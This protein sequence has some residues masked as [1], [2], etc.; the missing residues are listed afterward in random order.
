MA[1]FASQ[2]AQFSPYIAPT[3]LGAQAQRDQQDLQA[4]IQVGQHKQ[5]MY[6]VNAQKIQG[7][8][9]QVS[10][11]SVQKDV[12]KE[13]LNQQIGQMQTDLNKMMKSD[14]SKQQVFNQA[15]SFAARVYNDPTVLNAVMS[16]QHAQDAQAQI[17][18]AR[19]EG[20][21]SP[22]NDYAI[23]KQISQWM[24]DPTPGAQLGKQSYIPFFDYQKGFQDFMKDKHGNVIVRQDPYTK[25]VD[26]TPNWRAYA[27]VEGK[28]VE[29]SPLAVQQD[30]QT[31][32]QTNAQATQQL[33]LDAGYFADTTDTNAAFQAYQRSNA[34]GIK[35]MESEI[36]RLQSD[37]K[38]NV[39]N[40]AINQEQIENYKNAITKAQATNRQKEEAF[41]SNPTSAKANMFQDRVLQGFGN[42]FAYKD[43]EQ[44]IVKNPVFDAMLDED[45]FNLDKQKFAWG[46]ETWKMDFDQSERKMANDIRAAQI[47]SGITV[48]GEYNAAKAEAMTAHQYEQDLKIAAGDVVQG[49]LSTLYNT[50]A[51]NDIVEPGQNSTGETIYKLKKGVTQDQFNNAW[52]TAQNSYYDNPNGANRALK[53]YYENATAEGRGVGMQRAY[54]AEAKRFKDIK[55]QIESKYAQDPNFKSYKNIESQLG[56]TEEVFGQ[57]DSPEYKSPITRG[58]LIKYVAGDVSEIPERKKQAIFNI[59]ASTRDNADKF[60]NEVYRLEKV[61]KPNK[62]LY[63][64]YSKEVEEAFKN[65]APNR[66]KLSVAEKINDKNANKLAALT[67]FAMGQSDKAEEF[68]AVTGEKGAGDIILGVSKNTI[69]G[70]PTAFIRNAKG[71]TATIDIDEVLAG[72]LQPALMQNNPYAAQERI[73]DANQG[74]FRGIK[75][76]TGSPAQNPYL[77]K[78]SNLQNYRMRYSIERSADGS[79][80]APVVEY[81]QVGKDYWTPLPYEVKY[82]GSLQEA[83]AWVDQ[84]A[85]KGDQFFESTFLK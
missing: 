46:Q 4:Q 13:Y 44:K 28:E 33:G 73:L 84:V 29:L 15:G 48:G 5:S 21:S 85:S 42:R 63:N 19:A 62:E 39:G 71:T 55:E 7:M 11:L 38:I 8:V 50:G 53:D 70:K 69:T 23:Q 65:I 41:L 16:T 14:F 22:T 57:V 18:K 61:V 81:K 3:D 20:K 9:D 64:K 43:L 37:S 26:G 79:G 1:S 25:S 6:E 83:N 77:P 30:A 10:G 80:Y 66:S 31:Y 75:T 32:F 58:D 17:Q 2:P 59:L 51:Y 72:Q 67:T 49:Q 24:A 34:F 52:Q 60:K 45:K 40:S 27:L 68:A 35:Q 74:K 56:N 36:A 76:T 54:Y 82:M 12:D 78:V 47:A